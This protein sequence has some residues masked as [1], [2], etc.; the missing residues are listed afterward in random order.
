MVDRII[1]LH[2]MIKKNITKQLFNYALYGW[3]IEWEIDE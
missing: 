3:S 1:E 2:K